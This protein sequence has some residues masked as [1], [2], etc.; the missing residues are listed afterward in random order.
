[1]GC[2]YHLMLP[3]VTRAHK[4]RQESVSGHHMQ[5]HSL[6]CFSFSIS[7]STAPL[8]SS[9]SFAQKQVKLNQTHFL[10]LN[11][12]L[13]IPFS[14]LVY[15]D[16]DFLSF[17]FNLK[18]CIW[19]ERLNR[20]RAQVKHVCWKTAG[21][22]CLWNQSES[23]WC[24]DNRYMFVTSLTSSGSDSWIDLLKQCLDLKRYF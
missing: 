9:V 10:F 17:F 15:C 23:T 16:K 3:V 1:M 8:G 4:T 20:F 5:Y 14:D 19:T 12:Q 7:P 22:S 13:V 18:Q 21:A 24:Y 6:S 11:E 2:R